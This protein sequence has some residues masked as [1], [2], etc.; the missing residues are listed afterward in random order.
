MALPPQRTFTAKFTNPVTGEAGVGF[1]LF[2]ILPSKWTDKDGNQILIGDRQRSFDEGSDG[3]ISIPLIVTDSNED[4]LPVDNRFWQMRVC[5]GGQWQTY[6]FTIPAGAGS[7]D[8]TDVEVVTDT[9]SATTYVPVPGPA[10]DDG[11]PGK[12]QSVNGDDGDDEGNV[13]VTAQGV[14]AVPATGGT[15]TGSVVMEDDLAVG[16]AVTVNG[17]APLFNSISVDTYLDGDMNGE[18]SCAHRGSGMLY[19]EHTLEAYRASLAEGA[20]AVEVSAQLTKDG[21]LVC[22]HDADVERMTDLTGAIADYTYAQ[23]LNA[24]KVK[25]QTLLG[26]GWQDCDIPTVTQVLDELLGR[27]IIFLEPKTN[28]AVIPLQSLMDRIYPDAHETVVWKL[29]YQNSTEWAASRGYKIWLYVDAATTQEQADPYELGENQPTFWG[30]PHTASD[31]VITAFVERNDSAKKVMV[32]EVHRRTEQLRFRNLGVKGFMSPQWSYVYNRTRT[33]D[34]AFPLRVV[35][36]GCM[37]VANYDPDYAIHFDSEGRAYC[38]KFPNQSVMFGSST[39]EDP[40]ATWTIEFGMVWDTVPAA[41]VHAGI[42]FARTD[43]SKYQFSTA[44][45]VGGYHL[46]I[47]GNG[48]LQI[49]RHDPGVAAGV[50]LAENLAVTQPVAGEEMTFVV[51]IEPGT[52]TFERTDVD[53]AAISTNDTTYRGE[54]QHLSNGSTTTDATKPFFTYLNVP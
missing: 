2:D 14:G 31:E 27:C 46:A 8:L 32:W 4:I 38:D 35:E 1:A 41:S 11:A 12:I 10:G 52:I 44:N 54:Y 16:G 28:D 45:A 17:R 24:V 22:F 40:S 47:R 13:V 48:T 29:Y 5:M 49:Y 33:G 20:P 7:I 43:D 42:A 37:G 23:L 25:A 53:D 50:K 19:P 34:S 6:Q 51:T 15:F 30:V 21:V 3:S 36:P 26:D 18:F 39:P 9:V